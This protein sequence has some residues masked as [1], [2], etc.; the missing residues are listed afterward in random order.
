MLGGVQFNQPGT[1]ATG[2]FSY[3]DATGT[4]A[5]WNVHVNE[6][7][8]VSFPAFTYVP[9]NSVAYTIPGPQDGVTSLVLSAEMGMAGRYFGQRQVQITPLAPLDGSN[10]AVPLD[11]RSREDFGVGNMGRF[12]VAGSLLLAPAPARVVVQVDEFYHA[13]LRHYFMTADENE[14]AAL[15]SGVH[16]GWMRTGQSFKAYAPGSR[17]DGSVDPVCRFYSNPALELDSGDAG[18]D[19]HFFSADAGE[20]LAVYRRYASGFWSME[21]DNAF[22]IDLPDPATGV[23]PAN[24][25]PVYRLWNQRT[26]SNHRYT[27]SAGIKA[28]MLVS[29]YLAEGYGPKGV[30]MC[31][32]P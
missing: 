31:A 23:C 2:Y 24:T 14:K 13:R 28:E 6:P 21:I 10:A 7:F 22:Q 11:A 25:V 17:P 27:T 19:S 12:V 5:S 32:V 4:I 16:E 29:G 20:C 30:A 8:A 9:G 1:F 15:D 26:D 18:V 3:D